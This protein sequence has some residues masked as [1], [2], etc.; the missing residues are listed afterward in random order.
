MKVLLVKPHNIGDHIQ[1]P[2]GLGYLATAIRQR[3]EVRI[4]DCIKE[5]VLPDRLI[6][7][8]KNDKPAVVGIQCYTFDLNNI[9]RMLKGIKGV[10]A[11][12]ITVLGGPHPSAV[13]VET[14]ER[15]G[16][17]LDFAF[18][19]EAEKGFSKLLDRLDGNKDIKLEGVEGLVWRHDRQIRVNA[20]YFE[21]DLDKCGF[22]AWDLIKP[23]E[24]PPAQHGAFFK[25]FPI[26]PMFITRGCPFPCSFCAGK[27]VTGEKIR[28]HSIG[29]VLKEILTLYNK[30]GIR[31]FHI[32]DD[33]F[34]MDRDFSKKLLREI[35][36]L[37]LDISWATPNGIRM[38]TLDDELLELMKKSGLYLISLG[39][40]SGSDRM[41]KAMGK[42]ITTKKIIEYVDRIHAHRIPLAGFFI[43][44]YIDETEEEMK[45]TIDFSLKLGLLRANYFNFLPFPGTSSYKEILEKEGLK[46]IDFDKFYF[47][48]VAY[49]PRGIS[50]KRLRQ[51]QREA[52]LRFYLRPHVLFQNLR[53]IKS[54][55]HF[56]FLFKRFLNWLVIK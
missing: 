38:E 29:Y 1:P 17:D 36:K 23:Q 28:R 39:I 32:I 5:K 49:A 15:F 42:H 12:I 31:E 34:T 11:G 33:N 4:L 21:N 18:V 22:P 35:I 48:D 10:S 41:L 51:L 7:I 44:G 30:Y 13:P 14:M 52:F 50:P 45:A 54:I 9:G 24:Y 19:G 53:Q 26:A 43:L 16:M 6:E 47:M 25:K 46:K 27:L 2:L 8:I 37:N 3:H 56:K 20:P 55:A 40:E